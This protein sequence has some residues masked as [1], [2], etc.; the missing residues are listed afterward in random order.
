MKFNMIKMFRAAAS[1]AG[2]MTLT[3]ALALNAQHNAAGLHRL[4]TRGVSPREVTD[5]SS[6]RSWRLSEVNRTTKIDAAYLYDTQ[7]VVFGWIS[8]TVGLTTIIDAARAS[9]S[10]EFLAFYPK[11]TPDGLLC[12]A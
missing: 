10:L 4:S 2:V 6:G 11:S 7:V 3:I 5:A 8:A 9:E 12:F 1:I